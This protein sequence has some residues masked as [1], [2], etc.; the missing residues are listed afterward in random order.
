[1]RDKRTRKKKGRGDKVTM[2]EG[3]K[4][5]RGW[6]QLDK[7]TTVKGYKNARDKGTKGNRDT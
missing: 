3:H 1:M 7:G 6:R 4:G 2:A 5:T